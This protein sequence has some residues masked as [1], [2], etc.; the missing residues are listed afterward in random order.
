MGHG[1]YPARLTATRATGAVETPIS[2]VPG[3]EARFIPFLSPR[4]ASEACGFA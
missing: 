3:P 2:G 4:R 1:V